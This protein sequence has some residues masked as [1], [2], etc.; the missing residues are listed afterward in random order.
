MTDIVSLI[1]I[2]IEFMASYV[3]NGTEFENRW[4][5]MAQPL[6]QKYQRDVNWDED[7]E[8]L[9]RTEMEDEI[10]SSFIFFYN[11]NRCGNRMQRMV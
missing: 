8:F 6:L 7:E 1:N 2:H 4:W 5:K 3:I 9:R 10:F 11:P